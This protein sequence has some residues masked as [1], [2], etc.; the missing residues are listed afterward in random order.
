LVRAL[1]H[2]DLPIFVISRMMNNSTSHAASSSSSSSNNKRKDKRKKKE[3]FLRNLAVKEVE[4]YLE[5]YKQNIIAGF[6][7]AHPYIETTSFINKV[8]TD[9]IRGAGLTPA[10]TDPKMN[11]LDSVHQN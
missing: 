8:T 3:D 1:W 2:L 4:E 11:L 10:D 6:P 7:G 5:R 9:L